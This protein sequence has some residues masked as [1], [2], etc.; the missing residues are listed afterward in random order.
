MPLYTYTIMKIISFVTQ[1]GGSGKTTLTLNFAVAALQKKARVVIFD[2]D[3]QAT[4][5]KWY[6]RRIDESIQLVS[7]VR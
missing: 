5:K 2:L 7:L 6:E 4:A 3:V 1:K